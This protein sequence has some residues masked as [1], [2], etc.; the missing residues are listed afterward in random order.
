MPRLLGGE[1]LKTSAC[2]WSQPEHLLLSQTHMW[3]TGKV[4]QGSVAH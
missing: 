1:S 2:W 4:S 3:E